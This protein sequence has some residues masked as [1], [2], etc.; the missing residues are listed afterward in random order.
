MTERLF[1]YV[2]KFVL[3]FFDLWKKSQL[4]YFHDQAF[5]VAVIKSLILNL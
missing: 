1:Q 4:I 2:T 5:P 3:Y